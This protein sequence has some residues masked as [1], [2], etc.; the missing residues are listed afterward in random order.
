ML[1]QQD[2]LNTWLM[3]MARGA[4]APE[5]QKQLEERMV[6]DP[7]VLAYCQDFFVTCA[8]LEQILRSEEKEQ[9]GQP[10]RYRRLV[11]WGTAVAA[12][13]V[14]LIVLGFLL[15]PPTQEPTGPTAQLIDSRALKWAL[16]CDPCEN[17]VFYGSHALEILEGI[18]KFRMGDGTQIILKGPS[19]FTLEDCNCIYLGEGMLTAHVPKSAQGFVVN[20]RQAKIVDLGTEFGVLAWQDGTIETQVFSGLVDVWPSDANQAL[21]LS[22]GHQAL[23]DSDGEAQSY[24]QSQTQAYYI[25]HLPHETPACP[26]KSLDLADIVGGGNG[27]GYGV[28]NQ[29]IDP[30]NGA[31]LTNPAHMTLNFD[32]AVF[33]PIPN[34]PYIDG[35][36]LPQGQSGSRVDFNS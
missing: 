25:Q 1:E 14:I 23:I 21:H 15:L 5:D 34:H 9:W 7:E 13:L 22:S 24:N 11:G 16:D 8:N 29:G 2:P 27:F 33:T 12:V 6:S 3:Q 35:V 26:G 17:T 36:F 18:A 31:I 28:L 4:I 20:T 32:E 30:K 10:P 19:R